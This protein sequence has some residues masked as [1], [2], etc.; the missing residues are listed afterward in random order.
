MT[1][2]IIVASWPKNAR[3]ALV[4]KLANFK[5][6]PII[7]LRAWYAGE[8]GKLMPGRGGLTV[9]TRHL[10]ALAEA[11]GKALEIASSPLPDGQEASQNQ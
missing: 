9:S 10:P 4:V 1:A 5:G 6:Q 2:D 7:D 11:I 3:E 8:S